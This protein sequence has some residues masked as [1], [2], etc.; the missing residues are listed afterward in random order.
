MELKGRDFRLLLGSALAVAVLVRLALLLYPVDP[1]ANPDSLSFQAIAKTLVDGGR[2]GYVDRGI[3]GF[4]LRA[5]RSILYPIL[6][7]LGIVTRTGT[8][9]VLVIQ[10]LLGVAVVAAVAGIG[11]RLYGNTTGLV[12]AW[13]G[14]LYW[15]PVLWERQIMSE[16]L[17]TPLLVFGVL[18]S[19]EAMTKERGRRLR[20]LGG[21]LLFGLA[22]LVR[23]AGI[24][25]AAVVAAVAFLGAGDGGPL[26]S[27]GSWR[28]RL[29]VPAIVLG[30]LAVVTGPLVIRNAALL[31]RPVILTSGG[32]NFW[33]GN[34]VGT[35]AEAWAIM[36]ERLPSMGEVG[37]DRWFYE[38]LRARGPELARSAP[39]LLASKLKI[40][41]DPVSRNPVNQPYRW[42]LPLALAGFLLSRPRHRP[43]DWLVKLVPLSQ[44]ALAVV[45]LPGQRYRSPAD[46]FLW[47]LAAAAA[48]VL[49]RDGRRGRTVLVLY[50]LLQGALLALL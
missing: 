10:A 34:R 6:L 21:G 13:F 33:I 4:E 2:L 36:A 25:A 9:G 14:A 1:F 30:G 28:K 39:S 8:A 35:R 50:A 41:L 27:P 46:P 15:T 16:A 24:L 12:A 19:V 47:L 26:L 38:D 23:P 5:F 29:V 40:T 48:T 3:P 42:L 31:G 7:A 17:F 20:A 37:M 49:W 11:R 22:T 18:F 43:A 44:I 45:S 32:H